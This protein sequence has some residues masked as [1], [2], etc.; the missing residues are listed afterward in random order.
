[1]SRD[2]QI[3]FLDDRFRHSVN[4]RGF[5]VGITDGGFH[6]YFRWDEIRWHDKLTKFHKHGFRYFKIV[7]GGMHIEAQKHAD[8]H[9]RQDDLIKKL[10]LLEPT[11]A[12]VLNSCILSS[13]E[14]AEF[15]LYYQALSTA[16]LTCYIFHTASPFRAWKEGEHTTDFP[17]WYVL[18]ENFCF[19]TVLCPSVW[20]SSRSPVRMCINYYIGKPG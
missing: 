5:S 17:I 10:L 15:L 13:A 2:I 7:A 3:Q 1:M 20:H 4:F 16:Q 18:N 19:A 12:S 9:R 6:E 14:S 11:I 8:T